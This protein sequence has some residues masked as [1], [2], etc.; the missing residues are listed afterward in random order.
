M[1][2]NNTSA[3][4]CRPIEGTDEWSWHS[5]GMAIDVNPLYNPYYYAS[6]DIVLPTTAGAYI[7]RSVQTPYTLNRDDLCY[8]LFTSRGF[9][10]GGNWSYPKD[11]QHFEKHL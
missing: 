11:Y 10:W 9:E 2:A 3:F 5:Y 8:R 6:D 1:R 7:D 4:N